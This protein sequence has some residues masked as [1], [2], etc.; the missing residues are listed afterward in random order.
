MINNYVDL[1]TDSS[2]LAPGSATAANQVLEIAQLT[3]I[4]SNTANALTLL[5]SIDGKL[6]SPLAVTGPLTDLQLRAAPVVISGTVT[7]NLGTIAGVATEVTLSALNTKI[8]AGLTVTSTRLLVDGSGVTQPISGTVTANAGTNLNT[9]LLA[10]ESG[11]NLASINTKIPLNLTVTATRLLVDGSGVTQP[12]SAVAL[13]LPLGAST[14]ATLL[15]IDNKLPAKYNTLDFSPVGTFSQEFD[16]TGMQSGW[17][18]IVG[19]IGG[20]ITVEGSLNGTTYDGAPNN[21]VSIYPVGQG[22]VS[23]SNTMNDPGQYKADFSVWKKIKFTGTIVGTPAV[24]VGSSSLPFGIP[25]IP[26]GYVRTSGFILG[27]ATGLDITDT[28]NG[29]KISLDVNVSNTSIPISGSVTVSGTVAVSSLPAIT[30]TVTANAGTNLNTSLLTLETTQVAMSAKLPATLG[31]KAMAASMAVVLASD[32]SSIPVAATLSAETTKVIGTVNIASGQTVGLVA[33][34]A[35]V[36]K[37]GI[38]QTTPGTTNAVQANAGTNLNTSLLALETTQTAQNTL[39]G[40]INETAPASDTASSGLNGRLQRIAQRTTSLIAL[41]PTSLGQ[42]TMANSFA[43]TLAS[44]QTSIP[45][46]ATLAAETTKVIGTVNIIGGQT[47]ITAA[48]GAVAANTPRMTL[49][50]DDPAVTALQIMDDWD[51]TDRAKVNPVVGQ[52]GVQGASG[53]VSANTQRVVLATDVALPAGNNNIGD[54][55]ILSV[56]PGTGA[57]NLGKAEDGGHT[58]GDVGVMALGV[59]ND[60]NASLTS[61]D[62]DYSPVAV[63]PA[64]LIK[65]V[66]DAPVKTTYA[67]S[68]TNLAT[69]AN[70]TDVVT[71]SGSASKTIKI[72]EIGISGS[73]TAA[74][75][76]SVQLIKRSATNTTGTSTTPTVVPLDSA[77][78]AGTAVFRAYTANPGALGTVVGTIKAYKLLIDSTTIASNFVIYQHGSMPGQPIVLRGTGEFLGINFNATTVT[79][80]SMCI[81][82]IWTEE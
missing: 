39:I 22:I 55:D 76:L 8:P 34:S 13:P 19:S 56:I 35:I 16:T 51:E 3:A 14:E 20:T 17:I 72:V 2:T 49:A 50:S 80:S 27:G 70:A 31:Q 43:V 69:A 65:I 60:A 11:G 77:N 10:L 57:T 7:A 1:P 47:S 30:G 63:T 79:G 62:L 36:G 25:T 61:N 66:Q 74:I 5:T 24:Y 71:L 29:G 42:K 52:A 23:V 59:R 26:D 58:T 41:Y 38:D 28:D 33:G 48:A 75:T 6:T 73:A 45:V 40:A 9:S 37:F 68:I 12:I 32:Q 44:D 54:I 4:N 67:S 82:I 18:L 81:Y 53:T 15:S 21:A 78:A 46:A 64:G